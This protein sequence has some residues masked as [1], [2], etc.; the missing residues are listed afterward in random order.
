LAARLPHA[1]IQAAEGAG[2]VQRPE[3][4]RC[5]AS[6]VCERGAAL[7]G[8]PPIAEKGRRGSRSGSPVGG[9]GERCV[10]L[11]WAAIKAPSPSSPVRLVTCSLSR[12]RPRNRRESRPR[13]QTPLRSDPATALSCNGRRPANG[14]W[15]PGVV[16]SVATCRNLSPH[17]P[18]P[19]NWRSVKRQALPLPRTRAWGARPR[20]THR[21]AQPSCLLIACPHRP[22]RPSPCGVSVKAA[23]CAVHAV[24]SLASYARRPRPF[25]PLACLASPLSCLVHS[26]AP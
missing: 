7:C 4:M 15:T 26:M 22:Y 9:G 18:A 11:P 12:P 25:P 1:R 8:R 10:A 20:Q 13:R 19:E 23:S 2:I 5:S 14:R 6:A 24:L 16:V 17:S 21:S 3:R